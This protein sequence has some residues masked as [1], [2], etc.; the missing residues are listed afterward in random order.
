M[1]IILLLLVRSSLV[2]VS[3]VAS[4]DACGRALVAQSC[5]SDG[6]PSESTQGPTGIGEYVV[7]SVRELATRPLLRPNLLCCFVISVGF[8]LR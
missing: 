7:L 2:R 1:I 5:A 8:V 3:T 4:R 6:I